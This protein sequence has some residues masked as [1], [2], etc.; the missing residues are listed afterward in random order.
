[1]STHNE[2]KEPFPDPGGPIKIKIFFLSLIIALI[3]AKIVLPPSLLIQTYHN[4]LPKSESIRNKR[5]IVLPS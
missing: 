1:V 4:L 3:P 5:H 2:A